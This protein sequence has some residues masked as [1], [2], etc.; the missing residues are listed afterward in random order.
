MLP[1]LTSSVSTLSSHVSLTRNLA[2][3]VLNLD[4]TSQLFLAR[5]WGIRLGQSPIRL[6]QLP[7]RNDPPAGRAATTVVVEAISLGIPPHQSKR[8]T[9]P[10]LSARTRIHLLNLPMHL[11]NTI[12]YYYLPFHPLVF[13]SE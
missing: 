2:S 13:D 12:L 1:P 8:V 4:V 9:K 11:T 5:N 10:I 3:H 6:D 7:M